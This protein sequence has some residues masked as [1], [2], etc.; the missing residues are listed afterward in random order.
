[1][2]IVIS[3]LGKVVRLDYNQLQGPSLF[4]K[5]R[6][7]AKTGMNVNLAAD[8]SY[9]EIVYPSGHKEQFSF[10]LFE[11]FA[12]NDALFEYLVTLIA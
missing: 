8:S 2:N 9:V 3:D 1:M 7:I 5:V 6:T 11:G 12:S 4:Y 10:E